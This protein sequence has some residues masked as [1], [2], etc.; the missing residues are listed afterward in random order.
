MLILKAILE[1]KN[2]LDVYDYRQFQN[3]FK[4]EDF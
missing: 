2:P 3:N 1:E 4:M